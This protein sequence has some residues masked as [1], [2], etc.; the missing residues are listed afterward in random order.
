MTQ[1]L[2][3]E[4]T[5][6][7]SALIDAGCHYR[8][9]ELSECYATD[10]EIVMVQEDGTVMTFDYTQNMAF[11]QNLHDSGAPPLNTAVEFNYAQVKDDTGY[12]IATR[13]MDIGMGEK[14]IVFTLMLKHTEKGWKVFREHA[15]VSGL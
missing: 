1:S 14:K 13:R 3:Y 15:V 8:L 2:N 7:V 4:L 10:L 5:Q 9:P 6:A 11:F 12:V